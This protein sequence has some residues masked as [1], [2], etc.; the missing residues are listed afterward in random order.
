[1]DK[2][3]LD[4]LKDEIID[5]IL[6]K[7]CPSI[8]PNSKYV[9]PL[10]LDEII[11]KVYL[12]TRNC[13]VDN[14]AE[15][16]NDKNR[17]EMKFYCQLEDR[18]LSMDSLNPHKEIDPYK[19][20]FV[21]E[22]NGQ[23][24]KHVQDLESLLEKHDGGE[25]ELIELAQVYHGILHIG[26]KGSGK[27]LSQNV[28]LYNNNS[29]LEEN[30]I[31][32]VRLDCSKLKR[33]W[34]KSNSTRKVSTEKYLLGQLVYV[35][36]KHFQR[37]FPNYCS[38]LF[39][40]IADKLSIDI[41]NEIQ[42][43]ITESKNLSIEHSEEERF[44]YSAEKKKMKTI[45][46]YLTYFEYI[47]AKH[48]NTFIEGGDARKNDSEKTD[49][50]KSFF[51]DK[52]LIEWQNQGDNQLSIEWYAVANRLRNFILEKGY[53]L[54]YIIDGIDSISFFFA[55]RK[56]YINEMLS[57]L[58]DFPLKN[59]SSKAGKNELVMISLRDTTFETMKGIQLTNIYSDSFPNKDISRF[60][61][62]RQETNNLLKPFL[63]KRVDFMLDQMSKYH[64]NDCFMAKVLKTIKDFNVIIE[65]K[66]WHSNIRCF[67]YNHISLAKLI[68]FKYYFAGQPNNFNIKEQISIYEDDN[69]FLNGEAFFYSSR[70]AIS[71]KGGH[72]FN[73]FSSQGV[74]EKLHFIHTRVLQVIKTNPG[75]TYQRIESIVA[76]F[77]ASSDDCK[78]TIDRLVSAGMI[79]PTTGV[80][81]KGTT[82]K[83]SEK[84]EFV[85][86]SFYNNI[87]YLYYASLDTILPTQIIDKFRIAPNNFTYSNQEKRYYP[88]SCII[89]GAV[90][91]QYLIAENRKII[92]GKKT[93]LKAMGFATPQSFMELPINK[94]ALEKSIMSMLQIATKDPECI[95]IIKEWRN[96]RQ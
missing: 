38:P 80:F 71:N 12:D 63:D 37:K 47:I 55:D 48:E 46:D 25:L 72:C 68:T 65:E 96:T 15:Y 34:E 41:E 69:F 66:R 31:V 51:I 16:L 95:K 42:D 74:N 84:G 67:F 45:I 19:N 4:N 26:E 61:I 7:K 14:I 76:V 30:G 33:I 82:Y 94:K 11:N 58:Y 5:F 64:Y 17:D 54:F 62:I 36:S 3:E 6:N 70:P 50:S 2:Q 79:I 87:N 35:F 49:T 23:K 83:I 22:Y 40:Q 85:L 20:Y 10:E 60:F 75:I 29:K 39:A 1:M 86:S 59:S 43:P 57:M 8:K 18:I 93:K 13:L 73:L 91:L 32:W 21:S 56:N 78:P 77:H 90:F 89:T 92:N 28:W 52:I 44:A 88:A 81:D 53:Y 27:T 24:L 9:R